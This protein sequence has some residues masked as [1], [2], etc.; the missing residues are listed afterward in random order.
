MSR[1]DSSNARDVILSRVREALRAPAPVPHLESVHFK[2]DGELVAKGER[3]PRGSLP[4]LPLD[5]ARPWLPEGGGSREESLRLFSENSEKLK[6]CVHRVPDTEAAAELLRSLIAK[7]N[8]KRV[9]Y[10]SKALGGAL[11]TA[12]PCEAYCIDETSTSFN[13]QKLEGCDAGITVC[14]ALV[15]QTG[16]ILLSSASCGGRSLSILPHAHIVVATVDQITAT[17]GEA[18]AAAK[19]RYNGRMPSMLGFITGPS[20]TGDIERILVLGAHGPKELV[21]VI[22]G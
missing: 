9:A 11:V 12:I 19:A 2:E 1:S 6:T 4:I 13:K 21:V 5:A 3:R 7:H 10:H 15:A 17:I 18:L 8:W 16:S 14:E 22:V 20:R